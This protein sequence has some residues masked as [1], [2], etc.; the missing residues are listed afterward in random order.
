[1]EQSHLP[2]DVQD[3]IF[4]ALSGIQKLDD[5]IIEEVLEAY[6]MDTSF[7]ERILH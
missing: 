4:A 1:L 6:A 7:D 5:A 3:L 2:Y